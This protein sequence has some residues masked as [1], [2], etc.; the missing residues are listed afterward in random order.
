MCV[1]VH[2]CVCVCVCVRECTC[3]FPSSSLTSVLLDNQRY[4]INTIHRSLATSS[5]PH[6]HHP[7]HPPPSTRVTRP[8]TDYPD[9]LLSSKQLHTSPTCSLHGNSRFE[10]PPIILFLNCFCVYM[11]HF[12]C[13]CKCEYRV[14]SFSALSFLRVALGLSILHTLAHVHIYA[15]TPMQCSPNVLQALNVRY[16]RAFKIAWKLVWHSGIH[17]YTCCTCIMYT[18]LCVR[19]M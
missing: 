17:A 7:P 15:R 4:S 8:T 12:S 2:A 14:Y 18:C 6:T 10:D 3:L 11:T 9:L 13:V 1:C 16:K 5:H 19:T